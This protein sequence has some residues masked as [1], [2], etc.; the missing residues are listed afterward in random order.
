[1]ATIRKTEEDESWPRGAD[2]DKLGEP[3]YIVEGFDM[4]DIYWK[5][6]DRYERFKHNHAKA[7]FIA[8]DAICRKTFSDEFSFCHI[9]GTAHFVDY[10]DAL[11]FLLTWC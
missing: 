7:N 2:W 9:S 1:M 11:I 5:M 8:W 10:N 3:L 6:I 4:S